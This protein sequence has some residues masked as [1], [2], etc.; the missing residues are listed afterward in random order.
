MWGPLT[1]PS[2]DLTKWEKH[3]IETLH[4]ELCKN[5]LH[6]HRHTT[7]NACRAELG[8][9]PLITKIQKGQLNS[10]NI[11]SSVIPNHTIYKALQYQEMSKESKPFLQL[12]QSFSPDASLTSTDA[13]NHNIRTN[14]ITAQI[15][16][17]YITHWQTQTQQQSKMQCYLSL[18]REY[19]MAEYLFTCQIETE[20]H[21]DQIQTQRTQADDRWR[22]DTDKHGCPRSRDCVSHCDLNQMETELALP[23][24]VFQIHRY[25]D[26][27][28]RQIPADPS[29]IYNS[30]RPGETS[31]SARRTQ[32][33]L[34]VCCSICC[35]SVTT[36]E[37]TSV[38]P[39][40]MFPA[41]VDYIM[42][43]YPHYV[44]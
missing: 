13:L 21:V 43:Y 38:C 31:V 35:L 44:T 27:V 16:Q 12:I 23:D 37:K 42:T 36:E 14:Q 6:V 34:C 39:E 9:Y 1:N 19:S 20:K 26:S 2:Q 24:R 5:I 29:H 41:H 30:S 40:L 3:P 17:S 33:L 32:D 7:N 28:L 11:W 8:K 4:A 15:K 25:T 10:G 18:K 22:A